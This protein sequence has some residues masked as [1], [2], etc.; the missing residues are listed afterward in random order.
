M[1]DV[2]RLQVLVALAK[3]GTASAAAEA[4]HYSQPTVSHHLKRLEAETGAV[5]MRRV[6]RGLVLTDDGKRLAARGEEILGLITRAS[7]ELASAV[8]L[9]SGHVRLAIFPSGM[10]TLAPRIVTEMSQRHPGLQL[11]IAEAEPPEAERLLIEGK[12]D[13]AITFTY[14]QQQCS[15]AVTSDVMGEDPLY[16]VTPPARHIDGTMAVAGLV[17]FHD[18]DW[19]AGCERCRGYLVSACAQ[20][21]FQPNIRFASDDYVATQA[22]I[23]VG[24]GVTM[25]P[26]LALA[27]H[28]HPDVEVTRVEG[29]A[30]SLRLLS[31]GR[32]PLPPALDAASA[33]VKEI[34]AAVVGSPQ[35]VTVSP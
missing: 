15:D 29:A 28:R 14:P 23:A 27:A 33:V 8:S 6:G 9:H 32:P 19:L 7:T 24:H 12:V 10:A 3:Y 22:L 17:D 30:R 34:V 4:L 35:P 1:I 31:L 25:L 2:T 11:D 13:L 16:L 26:G 5:L 20:A 18:D 21:G